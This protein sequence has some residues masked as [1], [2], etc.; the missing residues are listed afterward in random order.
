MLKKE[1]LSLLNIIDEKVSDYLSSYNVLQNLEKQIADYR[2]ANKVT[3]P[4]KFYPTTEEKYNMSPKEID[5]KSIK[6]KEAYNKAVKELNTKVD[7]FAKSIWYKDLYNEITIEFDKLPSN[8]REL[9]EETN[10]DYWINKVDA[11][12]S[13]I[14]FTKSIIDLKDE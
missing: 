12:N 2:E 14:E 7:E 3:I 10:S 9:L 6:V 1:L 13:I 5:A 4:R 11:I 8:F